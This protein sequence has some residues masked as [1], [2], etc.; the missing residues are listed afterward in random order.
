MDNLDSKD[1][2]AHSLACEKFFE[3][4]EKDDGKT[5]KLKRLLSK[6]RKMFFF[7]QST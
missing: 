7:E 6:A 3:A 2:T 4:A 1:Q 5:K